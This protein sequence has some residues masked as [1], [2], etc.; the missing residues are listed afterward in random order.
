MPLLGEHLLFT[1]RSRRPPTH[2]GQASFPGGA[3]DRGAGDVAAAPLEAEEEVGLKGV[4]PLGFLSPTYSPQGF[5]VQPVVVFREDLPPLKPNPEEV[6]QILLAPLEELLA[7][8]PWNEVRRGRTVWHFPWRGVDI[9]GVTGNILKEFL[10]VWREA[11]RDPSRGP[12]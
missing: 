10:E 2:A 4:E 3:R 8:E 12:L 1:L 6:A 7:V 9:W 11:H 5:L